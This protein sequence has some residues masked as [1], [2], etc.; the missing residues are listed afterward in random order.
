MRSDKTKLILILILTILTS[1][2]SPREIFPIY[3]QDE[4]G[5]FERQIKYSPEFIG[6]VSESVQV[7]DENCINTVGHQFNDFIEVLEIMEESRLRCR[8]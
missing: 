6:F 5:C 8:E 2:N 3:F 1:C 7:P 4:T